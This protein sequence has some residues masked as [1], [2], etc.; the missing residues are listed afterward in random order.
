MAAME[1]TSGPER[2]DRQFE[3]LFALQDQ[4]TMEVMEVFNV[5]YSV[6]RLGKHKVFQT[7]QSQAYEYYLKGLYHIFRRTAAGLL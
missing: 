7:Q 2:Y 4:I 6:G 5:K 1:I 3:D